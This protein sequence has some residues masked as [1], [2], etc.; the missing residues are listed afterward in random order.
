[1]RISTPWRKPDTG[2]YYLNRAVPERL[3][4]EIGRKFVR[5]SLGS[6]DLAK[7]QRLILDAYLDSQREFDAADAHLAARWRSPAISPLRH[8]PAT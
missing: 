4:A 5:K 8:V 6:R 2:I 3:H 7:A 1:M